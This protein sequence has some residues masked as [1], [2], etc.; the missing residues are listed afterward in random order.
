MEEVKT[1]TDEI[2]ENDKWDLTR[3]F[4]NVGKWNEDFAWLQRT[5][6]SI[7]HLAKVAWA[8]R[9]KR[10]RKCSNS[11]SSSINKSTAFTLRFAAA[12]GRQRESRLSFVYGAAAEPPHASERSLR[13]R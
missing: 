9:Q 3:L 11:R 2:A 1:P 8:N 4:A 7:V 13:F 12:G 6:P 10:W 5:Y